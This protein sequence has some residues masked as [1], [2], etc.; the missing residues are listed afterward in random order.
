MAI[1]H[2]TRRVR[3]ATKKFSH[4]S[5]KN[6]LYDEKP[7]IKLILKLDFIL[8]FIIVKLLTF[9]LHNPYREAEIEKIWKSE[10]N[11]KEKLIVNKSIIIEGW[12]GL[13]YLMSLSTI[14][15]LYCGGQLYWWRKLEYTEKT[16]V[17]PQVTDK[18]YHI[19]L[20]RVHPHLSGI[21]THNV[22]GDRHWLHILVVINSWS[23][24]KCTV[25]SWPRQPLYYE[26]MLSMS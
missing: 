11:R 15:Q 6:I 25:R 9:L 21:Q 4:H 14:F 20:Y 22:S 10:T 1:D 2:M 12:G 7:K 8:Y 3:W 23:T 24:T 26:S 18:L 13:W 19:M 16:T 17:L 5:T